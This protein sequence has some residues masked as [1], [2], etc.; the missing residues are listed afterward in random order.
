[1]GG[2]IIGIYKTNWL[3]TM[4]PFNFSMHAIHILNEYIPTWNANLDFKSELFLKN[5]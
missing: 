3:K 2:W 1:M 4:H 5:T